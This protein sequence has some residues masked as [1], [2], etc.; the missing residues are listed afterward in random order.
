MSQTSAPM[1][2][3]VVLPDGS[4]SCGHCHSLNRPDRDSCY[5]CHRRAPWAGSSLKPALMV[6]T[7]FIA[8][9]LVVGLSGMLFF[10][11][12]A[13]AG[14]VVGPSPSP[15]LTPTA[16]ASSSPAVS[17]PPSGSRPPPASPRPSLGV[18]KADQDGHLSVTTPSQAGYYLYSADSSQFSSVSASWTVPAISCP[19]TNAAIA[20]WV[21]LDDNVAAIEQTG[22]A[23]DCTNGRPHYWFFTELGPG[24]A[25][26]PSD[27][28]LHPG[29]QVSAAVVFSGPDTYTL[30]MTDLTTKAHDRLVAHVSASRVRAEWILE[31]PPPY[32]LAPFGSLTFSALRAAD[33][34]SRTGGPLTSGWLA[35]RA[36]LE[37]NGNLAAQAAPVA[38]SG[39]TF[40]V[41]GPSH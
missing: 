19:N 4:W 41:H 31:A 39:L 1:P 23:A 15:T 30:T 27:L 26:V 10:R 33:D 29:D 18:P 6:L 5:A 28:V 21:G 7:G 38:K 36:D 9:G 12:G 2:D 25:A 24:A 3:P 16:T 17:A 32:G 22:T 13:T 20:I 35:V 11:S 8:L 14:V 40:T 37:A 34:H